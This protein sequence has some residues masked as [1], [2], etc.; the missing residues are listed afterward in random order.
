MIEKNVNLVGPD[1]DFI[2]KDAWKQGPDQIF[3]S[4]FQVR[5]SLY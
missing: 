4:K 1:L 3:L 5:F 2:L